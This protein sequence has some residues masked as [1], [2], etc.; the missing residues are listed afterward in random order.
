MNAELDVN[1]KS[2]DKE[3]SS[4]GYSSDNETYRSTESLAAKQT[5]D[6]FAK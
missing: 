3:S 1:V 4:S 2:E 5:P 6:D